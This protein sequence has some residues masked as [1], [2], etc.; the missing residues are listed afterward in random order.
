V[1]PATATHDAEFRERFNREADIAATLWHPHIVGVHDRGEFEGQLWISMDYVDGTDAAQLLERRSPN[2]MPPNEVCKI[3]TAVAEALDY[4]HERGMLHRDVK[5]AN[6]LLTDPR[7]GEQRILLADFGIARRFEDVTGRLTATNMTV[8]TVAYAAPEQLLGDHVDGRADQYALA[9]TAY[10]LLTGTPPFSHSNPAVVI[11][12]HLTGPVPEIANRRPEL[13]CLDPTLSRGL[14]KEPAARFG[15]CVDFAR[16][17]AD[18]V[19]SRGATDPVRRTPAAMASASSQ[20]ATPVAVGPRKPP[21]PP[22]PRSRVRWAILLPVV[23]VALLIGGGTVFGL[24]LIHRHN[25]PHHRHPATASP[26]APAP[27]QTTPAAPVSSQNAAAPTSEAA[28][29]TSDAALPGPAT[30]AP[31]AVIGA[32]C[33]PPGAS[34]TTDNGSAAYCSRLQSID[35]YVWSLYPGDV[36]TPDAAEAEPRVRVCMD[37]TGQTR[38]QCRQ[39]IR[40]SDG[41]PPILNPASR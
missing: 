12:Q 14:A 5:P 8:G 40:A 33:G 38:P 7:L 36:V 13:S 30:G 34:G 1:L 4:A 16:A 9:A 28:A 24:E 15:R 23:L 25:H 32:T 27:A 19:E 11:S 37:Q 35:T 29:P 18:T 26:T 31:V 39:E 3:I 41:A 17:L 22:Q 21:P 20:R 6:I 2:G 10:H